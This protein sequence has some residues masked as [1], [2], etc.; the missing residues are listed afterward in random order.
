MRGDAVREYVRGSL[1][2]IP[3]GCVI[4]ALLLGVLLSQVDVGPSSPLAFQGTAD[5]ARALLSGISST[6][7][8]VIAVVLGLAVVALQLSSTQYSPRLLRNYLRDRVNQVVLGVLVGTFAFSAGGLFTVG[9]AGGQRNDQFPRF[10]VSV[11]I[12]LMFLSLALLVYFAHHLAH[13][14]QVDS[15]MGVVEQSALPVICAEVFTTEEELPGPPPWAVAMT[16][17]RSGYVQAV[18]LRDLRLAAS[19]QRVTLRLG[20]HVGEHV[21]AGTV[22]AWAW[23][24][25]PDEG[26]PSETLLAATLERAVRIGFERTLEQDLG[27]G[28]RQLSDPACK[29][30]SPAVNDPYTAVQAIDHLAVLFGALAAR[31]VGDHVAR[32]DD[33]TVRLIV[34]GR[35]FAELLGITVGLIRRYGAA[36]PTVVQAL[37]RLLATCAVL[38][39]E[40]PGRWSDIEKQA[41]LLVADAERAVVQPEDVA[42]VHA[43]AEIV[44]RVLSDRRAA[45]RAQLGQ[46]AREGSD[47]A[48]APT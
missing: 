40:D 20:V 17:R 1:W 22:L 8:T 32:D 4:G 9:V 19:G 33:G 47:A 42:S 41:K 25:S 29:A 3:T 27:L 7:V 28:F 21:V 37:L 39:I 10:A 34:P 30:L 15:I 18:D 24:A 38:A 45:R 23:S 12:A 26:A 13:S 35:R 48:Q 11:A 5:D 2:V 46:P 44:Q 16:A 6:M 43:Q 36:E 31:P 14:I